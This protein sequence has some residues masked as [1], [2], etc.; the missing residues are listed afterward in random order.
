[1]HTFHLAWILLALSVWS[2]SGTPVCI[3]K[4]FTEH[5]AD[6]DEGHVY[7]QNERRC[8]EPKAIS[9]TGIISEKEYNKDRPM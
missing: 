7:N 1:M 2:S 4:I 5:E 9:K 8:K 6:H 3:N